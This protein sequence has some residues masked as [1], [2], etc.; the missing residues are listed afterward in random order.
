MLRRQQWS[1]LN[2]P[3]MWSAAKGNRQCWT[4]E[5]LASRAELLPPVTVGGVEVPG[6]EA[7][8]TGWNVLH[9]AMRSWGNESRRASRN[10]STTKVPRPTWRILNLVMRGISHE[11]FSSLYTSAW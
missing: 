4:L 2:V 11:P 5:W 10:G 8:I 1:V 3:L 6:R 9:N 7:E